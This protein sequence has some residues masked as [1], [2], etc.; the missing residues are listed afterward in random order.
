[1][2][3]KLFALLACATERAGHRSGLI[4]VRPFSDLHYFFPRALLRRV[5]GAFEEP[6]GVIASIEKIPALVG[7]DGEIRAVA[8]YHVAVQSAAVAEVIE[9]VLQRRRRVPFTAD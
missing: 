2:S 5:C 7:E 3:T 1:M 8:Q 9:A 6:I 4:E